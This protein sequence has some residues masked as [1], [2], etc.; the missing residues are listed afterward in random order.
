MELELKPAARSDFT[1]KTKVALSELCIWLVGF[2]EEQQR[3]THKTSKV[4]ISNDSREQLEKLEV[5]KH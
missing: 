5:E 2:T 1:D 3:K 4:E